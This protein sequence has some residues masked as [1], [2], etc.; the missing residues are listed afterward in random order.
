MCLVRTTCTT[1]TGY[2]MHR[3]LGTRGGSQVPERF[4]GSC[5]RIVHWTRSFYSCTTIQ[6]RP[7]NTT[8]HSRNDMNTLWTSYAPQGELQ[9]CISTCRH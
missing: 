3:D 2:H 9:Y 6:A 8:I 7:K 5:A 4:R 1:N